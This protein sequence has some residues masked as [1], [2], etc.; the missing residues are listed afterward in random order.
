M[1]ITSVLLASHEKGVEVRGQAHARRL[2]VGLELVF[3]PAL[4]W[5]M[6]IKLLAKLHSDAAN[7]CFR[8]CI[9]AATLAA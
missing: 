2:A 5:A 4:A 6:A 1:A 9:G 8:L 7:A 3:E